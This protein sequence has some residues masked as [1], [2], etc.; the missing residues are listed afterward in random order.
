M[1]RQQHYDVVI[2]GGGISG[3]IMAKQLSRAKQRVLILEAGSG[4][5]DLSYERYL[6]YLNNYYLAGI[7]V[8]NAPYP[9]NPNAPQPS[10]LDTTQITGTTPDTNGYFVQRGPNP[11][12]SDY[13]RTLGGTTM[14]W[15]GTT[16]RMLPEDFQLKTKY[17]QG[18]DWPISYEDLM[19]YYEQ[20][21][22]EIGV[23]ADVE[24]QQF[25]GLHYREGYVFPMHKIPQSYLDQVLAKGLAGLE[26]ERDGVRYPVQVVSTP[27]G[28]N[29]MPNPAYDNGRG[30]TPIGAVGQPDLGQRCEGNSSCVP[31]CPVQAKYN[32]WKTLDSVDKDYVEIA[33]QCVASRV[34]YDAVTGMIKGIEYKHY[35]SEASADYTT[36]IAR[37][38]KYVLAAHAI[39]NAKLLLASGIESSSGM[40][41][42][43]L[44]DHPVLLTWATMPEPI[45]P[46]RGPGSTSGIPSLRAGSFRAQ[47]A[48]WRIEIDNWGWNW[49]ANAPY[50]TVDQLVDQGNLFGP[51]LRESFNAATQGQVRL[52]FLVEQL[53][54]ERN[55][56]TIDPSY[57]D[58]LG[59]YRPII[60][61]TVTDYTK[62]GM[63]AAKA[64]AD[65]MYQYLGA[66]DSTAYNPGAPGYV[67]YRGQG[68][69]YNGA[70][71]YVGTHIMGTTPQNSVVDKRQRCWDHPNLYLVGC[72][73]MP[74]IATSNPTLTMT[75]LTFWAAENLLEDLATEAA[76]AALAVAEVQ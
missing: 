67:V 17:G 69:A 58:R 53:P 5:P 1:H 19:P 68:Y 13:A 65:A 70:G 16:L 26:I 62:A 10:V 32:A 76:A 40:V 2:V 73:N 46:F 45:G 33:T 48:A 18:L 21:E 54:D 30:Y 74:T 39:E 15:L 71:H 22:R 28:R 38:T 23:S 27:V 8:P 14:H 4:T 72:G 51:A 43:N 29:S 56:V 11:F 24:D 42:R 75:A 49:A 35:E 41:G 31:I 44:M 50:S 64:T 7:K 66:A 37:G 25:L 36:H 60:D 3:A 57:T 52:G 63:A 6:T 12:G 9:N 47:G 55:R 34:L 20:A 59:N 61:Y